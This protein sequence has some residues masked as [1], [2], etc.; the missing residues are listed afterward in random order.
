MSDKTFRVL[1]L[2]A[3]NLVRSI[4]TQDLLDRIGLTSVTDPGE[5]SA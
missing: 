1:V 4:F 5:V 2:C 3:G